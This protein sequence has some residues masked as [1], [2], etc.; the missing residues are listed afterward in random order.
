MTFSFTTRRTTGTEGLWGGVGLVASSGFDWPFVLFISDFR[1]S[2]IFS[3]LKTDSI[4]IDVFYV[5]QDKQK[6][7][8][9]L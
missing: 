3:F 2:F 8:F 1:W 4:W 7:K 6:A 9:W 5:E